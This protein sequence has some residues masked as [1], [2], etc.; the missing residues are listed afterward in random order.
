MHICV[1]EIPNIKTA[2][3]K[4]AFTDQTVRN[5][6]NRGGWGQGAKINVGKLPRFKLP[7]VP[8]RPNVIPTGVAAEEERA[9]ALNEALQACQNSEDF[10]LGNYTLM[11]QIQRMTNSNKLIRNWK[12]IS[13]EDL[14]KQ[15]VL[16]QN[17]TVKLMR[18]EQQ[19]HEKQHH[20]DIDEFVDLKY[21][22][23]PK[24]RNALV[25]GKIKFKIVHDL[26]KRNEKLI[27]ATGIIFGTYWFVT[28]KCSICTLRVHSQRSYFSD[29]ISLYVKNYSC[30][31][32]KTAILN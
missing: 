18:D 10:N 8:V 6:N 24:I 25:L 5:P 7:L 13:I 27:P 21:A 32:K 14:L 11:D 16:D 15:A 30:W 1:S 29:N 12:N 20:S 3:S 19:K 23:P 28:R 17:N 4:Y 2:L 22:L 26:K 9:H 31:L